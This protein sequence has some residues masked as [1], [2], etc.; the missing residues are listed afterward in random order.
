[1]DNTTPTTKKKGG[2]N[3][4]A[5]GNG[6]VIFILAFRCI[7]VGQFSVFVIV[8]VVGVGGSM[9]LALFLS[10]IGTIRYID[11]KP[12]HVFFFWATKTPN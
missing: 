10:T 7:F 1:M 9:A 4:K 11:Q 8:C 6:N 2:V 3:T 12:D 5:K